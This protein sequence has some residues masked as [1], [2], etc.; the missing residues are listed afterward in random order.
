MGQTLTQSFG[1]YFRQHSPEDTQQFAIAYRQVRK[2]PE[3]LR[4]M[5]IIGIVPIQASIGPGRPMEMGSC[6]SHMGSAFVRPHT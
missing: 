1:P 5:A 4:L 2:A 3:T 6:T